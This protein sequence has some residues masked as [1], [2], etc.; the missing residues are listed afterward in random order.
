MPCLRRRACVVRQKRLACDLHRLPGG[1]SLKTLQD[2]D[3]MGIPVVSAPLHVQNQPLTLCVISPEAPK[4]SMEY[5]GSAAGLCV[6][7][8]EAAKGNME[9]EGSATGVCF[10]VTR[11]VYKHNNMERRPYGQH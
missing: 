10:L 5:E 3:A 11:H 1:A 4:G 7:S 9:Y 8:P 6:I 2:A